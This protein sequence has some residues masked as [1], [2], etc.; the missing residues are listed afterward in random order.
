MTR[1]QRIL[2]SILAGRAVIQLRA[3][4]TWRINHSS[5]LS[6]SSYQG[7]VQWPSLSRMH[8]S[9]LSEMRFSETE[10]DRE[11]GTEHDGAGRQVT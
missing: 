7:S 9:R 3:Q 8:G 1:P 11:L 4:V 2:H 5:G 6:L 10:G